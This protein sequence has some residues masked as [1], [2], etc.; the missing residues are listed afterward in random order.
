MKTFISK[1]QDYAL[2]I[3]AYLCGL[4]NDKLI[5]V[6]E[7][8]SKLAISYSFAARIV[9][10]LKNEKIIKTIQG[11]KGGITLN[12]SARD[13]S[14]YDVIMAIGEPAKIN[15]CVCPGIN[16]ELANACKF[17]GYFQK[18]ENDLYNKFKETKI[19]NFSL[20]F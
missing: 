20:T 11:Q 13:V 12:L 9:H 7:L 14:V 19:S 1:E 10:K 15:D 18:I 8:S 5:S 6:K 4:E 16:H 17:H 2:R 3:V